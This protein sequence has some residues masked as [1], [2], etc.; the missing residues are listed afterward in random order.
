[1]AAHPDE[2]DAKKADFDARESALTAAKRVLSE[3]LPGL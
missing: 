1:L 2:V 3:K